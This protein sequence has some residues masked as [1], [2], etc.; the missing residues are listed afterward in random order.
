MLSKL[1]TSTV[2]ATVEDVLPGMGMAYL[3]GDDHR[4]WTV[5]RS[6]GGSQFDDLKPG[7]RITLLIEHHARHAVVRNYAAAPRGAGSGTTASITAPDTAPDVTV[8]LP[9][10]A[11]T[12]SSIPSTS[13]SRTTALH[14]PKC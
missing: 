7:Q 12:R 8:S 13:K 6:T 2:I 14:S 3:A 4:D 5:T 11:R 9:P 10:T 1:T